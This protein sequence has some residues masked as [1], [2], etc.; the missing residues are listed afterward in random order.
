MTKLSEP[1][2]LVITMDLQWV[3]GREKYDIQHPPSGPFLAV[4][5]IE[6]P[7][8]FGSPIGSTD[9]APLSA[10]NRNL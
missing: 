1:L 3:E 6:E 5:Y 7:V 8:S 10:N 9:L 2:I 4:K